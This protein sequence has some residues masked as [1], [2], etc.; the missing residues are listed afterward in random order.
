MYTVVFPYNEIDSSSWPSIEK[1]KQFIEKN[2]V[3]AAIKND[4]TDKFF[5]Y[6]LAGKWMSVN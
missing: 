1:A 2:D 5:L 3:P 4:N 6:Y